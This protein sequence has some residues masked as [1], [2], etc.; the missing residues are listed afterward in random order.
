VVRCLI[1]ED[2]PLARRTLRELA[3]EVE[4]LDIVGE[5]EDGREALRMI[6]KLEPD[7]VFLDVQM[8]ELSGLEV[9]ERV[10]HVPAVVFTTAFDKYAVAAFE[11]EAVDYLVKP[12]GRKR[13]RETLERVHRRLHPPDRPAVDAG[14][15]HPAAGADTLRR[16]FA[17]R[18]NTIVPFA[19]DSVI[20][21]EA[22]QS[23][24]A[25]HTGTGKFLLGISLTDLEQ[26]LDAERF[27]RVHR[28][29]IVNLDFVAAIEPYDDRRV[30]VRMRDGSAVVAS[31]S[32]SQALR[33]LAI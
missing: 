18:G 10:E 24:V 9:L 17:R 2:E 14:T 5:A 30:V 12:F 16:L 20:R 33:G 6:N 13:F 19:V 31:R 29:H 8:P 22:G 1:A 15:Y 21:F 25:A 26:R 27:R 28:A 32:G 11:L 7:L 3:G 4:W 23:Y